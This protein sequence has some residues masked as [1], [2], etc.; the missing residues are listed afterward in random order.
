MKTKSAAKKSV[1]GPLCIGLSPIVTPRSHTLILG[2]MLGVKSLELRQYYA[3]PQ[4]AF[5]KIM[6]A[7]HGGSLESY[8][9]RLAIIRDNGLALWDTLK[10]CTRP[11]S[12]DSK[13]DSASIEVNDFATLFKK[14]IK[15]TRVFFNGSKSEQEFRRRVLPE[16]PEGIR[17]RLAFKKL[18]STSPAHAGQR[19]AEK[20]KHWR[21]I[22]R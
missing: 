21:A 10:C 3:H 2:S 19:F 14:H 11:G 17:A 20:V 7:L 4:N 8:E 15:I 18:P 9:D 13:I 16:L 22:K 1:K 6:Q 12:L 5:W